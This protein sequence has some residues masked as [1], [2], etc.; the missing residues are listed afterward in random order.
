MRCLPPLIV[1]AALALA[2]CQVKVPAPEYDVIV[3]GGT[4]YDGSG[5]QPVIADV[6]VRGQRIASIGD[7][8]KVHAAREIDAKGMAVAPGFVNMLSWAPDSLYIDGRSQSDIRQGV[9]LEVFGEGE[10]LGPLTDEIRKADLAAQGDLKHPIDWTTLGEGLDAL[11]KKGI[12][13][14]I[15]SF[16]GAATIREHEL[17]YVDRAPTPDELKRMQDLVRQA[18]HEGALGVGSALIYAPAFY[19][20]TPELIA[21]AQAAGE[22]GGA[23]I[24]HMRS[25]G[26]RLL[27]SLGE[28]MT[29]AS[30]AHIHGEVYHFKAA[31]AGN[32]T[33]FSQ[34]IAKIDEARAKGLDISANMY[35]YT[36]GA[37]GLDAAMPPWVQEGGVEAW[38]KRL[39]DPA[40]RARVAKEMREP[41]DAWENLL[42]AAGKPDNVLLVAFDSEALKPLTGK[43]LAEVAKL[44]GKSAEETAMDLV[45]EDHSRVGTVYFLM[46]EDNVKLGLSQPWVALG[47]DEGSYAPEGVFLKF[48]PHPRAYGNFARFLGHYVRDGHVASL[49]DAVRRLASLPAH[50]LKLHDR[51]ELKA[52]NFA[53]IVIFDPATIDEHAT[54]DHPQQYA[55]GMRDVFVNGVQVLKNGEH[56]GATPG[57][58][59]RG[60]GYVAK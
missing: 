5:G 16:V 11:V 34:A 53:D 8:G 4:I 50:N 52:G 26:N 3:R 15:A 36:A 59:V 27:E 29:I 56:T 38:I 6:G 39:K 49:A 21:L 57:Q 24:S 51:G 35:T 10:S 60:P 30:A 28:L 23:Y 12:S 41:T 1:T 58:V 14:N 48:Q 19:A 46:S 44:R 55:T 40:I 45:V 2:A 37:T 25:E 33:K 32:W 7:L 13:P 9:T 17:G 47:S 54:F 22:S 42:I 43:T 18:M 31:G 20:K